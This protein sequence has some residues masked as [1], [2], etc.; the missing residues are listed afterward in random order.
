VLYIEFVIQ[1]AKF[2]LEYK[3]H[4]LMY[5]LAKTVSTGIGYA[6]NAGGVEDYTTAIG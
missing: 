3:L 1:L 4:S 2:Q 5:F 6:S